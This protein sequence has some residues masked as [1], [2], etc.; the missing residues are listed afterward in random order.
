MLGC[1]IEEGPNLDFSKDK[2]VF[3]HNYFV[4]RFKSL[5]EVK[6]SPNAF[7][8]KL[9]MLRAWGEERREEEDHEFFKNAMVSLVELV[10][11]GPNRGM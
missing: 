3:L 10:G 7:L 2:V 6:L 1:Q 8:E 5:L 11:G 4:I 9:R